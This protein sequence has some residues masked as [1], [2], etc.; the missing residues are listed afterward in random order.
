MKAPED[1]LRRIQKK[2]ALTKR[3][4]STEN[5]NADLVQINSRAE[6]L[7]RCIRQS[8]PDSSRMSEF[9]IHYKDAWK[10]FDKQEENE[11]IFESEWL[12]AADIFY[13]M[14]LVYN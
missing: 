6:K 8:T 2:I 9:K 5:E 12:T 1:T 4:R 11:E 7:S 10:Q 13:R 3:T 14:A